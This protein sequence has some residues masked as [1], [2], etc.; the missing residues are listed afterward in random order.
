MDERLS[1]FSHFIMEKSDSIDIVFRN[2]VAN[3]PQNWRNQLKRTLI[4]SH[5][6]LKDIVCFYELMICLMCWSLLYR[7]IK[8]RYSASISSISSSNQKQ[9]RWGQYTFNTFE[10]KCRNATLTSSCGTIRGTSNV[11]IVVVVS[12]ALDV[13]EFGDNEHD[14]LGNSQHHILLVILINAHVALLAK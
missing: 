3:P 10:M 2:V 8:L 1:S 6:S 14:K 11:H 5:A 13:M 4:L 7:L 9:S 12:F